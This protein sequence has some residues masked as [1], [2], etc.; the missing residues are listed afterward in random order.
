MSFKGLFERINEYVGSDLWKED[1]QTL[2]DMHLGWL[3]IGFRFGL[4]SGCIN[5]GDNEGVMIEAFGIMF[6]VDRGKIVQGELYQLK[7]TLQD[8]KPVIDKMY[9]I[10]GSEDYKRL[11]EKGRGHIEFDR[12]SKDGQMGSKYL[13][14]KYDKSLVDYLL[15]KNFCV[16]GKDTLEDR[17]RELNKIDDDM[18]RI[19]EIFCKKLPSVIY[20][21]YFRIFKDPGTGKYCIKFEHSA[22]FPLTDIDPRLAVLFNNRNKLYVDSPEELENTLGLVL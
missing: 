22:D 18:W 14:L 2:V 11:V 8:W 3:D 4:M 9:E 6:R 10:G 20:S 19:G 7:Y 17:I 21:R 15:S 1:L 16:W 13:E 5:L 12:Y